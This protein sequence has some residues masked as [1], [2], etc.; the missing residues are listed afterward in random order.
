MRKWLF[1]VVVSGLSSALAPLAEGHIIR[2][3]AVP[4]A[5]P[6]PPPEP[7]EI[8]NI[9][10]TGVDATAGA[11]LA[12]FETEASGINVLGLNRI[13]THFNGRE[14]FTVRGGHTLSWQDVSR[15]WMAGVDVT[16]VADPSMIEGGIGGTVTIRT[17]RPLAL[18]DRHL[19]FSAGQVYN[20]LAE[21]S[22]PHFSLL[23]NRKADTP[24][25]GV[26]LLVTAM[27]QE[28][29]QRRDVI[30]LDPF[31]PR[32]DLAGPEPASRQVYMPRG[33]G[34]RQQNQHQAQYTWSAALQ[35]R[36]SPAFDAT[37]QYFTSRY[38]KRAIQYSAGVRDNELGLVPAF[39]TEFTVD[40]EGNFHSGALASSAWR[41]NQTGEG[42]RMDGST[43]SGRRRNHTD[44]LSLEFNYAPDSRWALRANAQTIKARTEAADFTVYTGRYLDQLQFDMR[45]SLPAMAV[46]PV[47]DLADA[48]AYF[49]NAAMDHWEDS[50]A[51]L[52][53]GRLDAVFETGDGPGV[54]TLQTGARWSREDAF[55]QDSGYNWRSI[56]DIWNEPLLGVTEYAPAHAQ[57]VEATGFFRGASGMDARFWLP[58]AELASNIGLAE[59]V[60]PQIHAGNSAEV[61]GRDPFYPQDHSRI[62]RETLA[63]YGLVKFEHS[64][65]QWPLRG[66]IGVRHVDTDTRSRGYGQFVELQDEDNTLDD[67]EELFADGNFFVMDQ[68][69]GYRA[70]LPGAQVNLSLT[71]G[72]IWRVAL[73]QNMAHPDLND[74]RAFAE[75]HGETLSLDDGRRVVDRWLGEAG[76]PHLLPIRSSQFDT[77]VEWQ[78][79]ASGRTHAAGFYKHLA[80][81]FERQVLDEPFTNNGVTR[82]VKVERLVNGRD[83]RIHGVE[84]GVSQKMGFLSNALEQMAIE[85][86]YARIESDTAMTSGGST[87]PL[88]GLSPNNWSLSGTY[89]NDFLRATFNY[90]WR[91]D[92]LQSVIDL[93]TQRPTW[94]A[95]AGRLDASLVGILSKNLE[96]ALEAHN[97]AD[98]VE[99]TRSGPY[100]FQ[101]TRHSRLHPAS[102][103]VQDRQIRLML[104]GR[105]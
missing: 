96:L 99:H 2:R 74:L 49:W 32:T 23:F 9:A 104:R 30:Y 94:Q 95:S 59:Q 16:K 19:A 52:H 36:T 51:T 15:E 101:G 27:T 78:F 13:Q 38:D 10:S 47:T 75:V 61:W 69:S 17:H 86:K 58:S 89:Q 66:H 56:S 93:D 41:G 90:R 3:Q 6:V 88:E 5:A 18:D 29:T 54:T 7:G 98:T 24:I 11:A 37:L 1:F 40:S 84:L 100:E 85:V 70:W 44:E 97:L 22:D 33:F 20:D 34:W 77:A 21:E 65:F 80:D 43:Q 4:A 8:I 35:V 73:S 46:T 64:I 68:H 14:T 62:F 45:G 67:N 83:A 76:S 81:S 82:N 48:E 55:I 31:I 79:S 87:L 60:I 42:V 103:A 53:T 63:V 72:V 102:W 91:D 26:G 105:F 25:G 71:P 12:L 92:W 50:Y 28:R 39:G 57:L